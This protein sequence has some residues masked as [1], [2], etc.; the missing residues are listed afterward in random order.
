M[1]QSVA[2]PVI[3][4]DG[5]SG[6]GKGTLSY[7][8]ARELGFHLLDSGALY[9]LVALAALRSGVDLTLAESVG[10]IAAGLD[11]VFDTSTDP[12]TVLLNGKD[13]TQAIREEQTGMTASVVAAYPE[14]RAALLKRQQQ[15]A[16]LP[17][18]VADGRD[19]GTCVFPTAQHK[20]FLTASAEARAERRFL[21]LEAKGEVVDKAVLIR[22]I[23]ARDERDS[24][25]P[26]SPLK[27]ASDAVLIDS[28]HLSIDEVLQG[29]LKHIRMGNPPA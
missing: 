9:R 14:V 11:V 7:L 8:L 17:G 23:R 12:A 29:M 18:L 5:P 20:F 15:F 19:M 24:N 26:V 22:D 6:A 27:P 28:T 16:Q 10:E 3:T 25:R 21:Q 2:I 1:S 4:I 13:V